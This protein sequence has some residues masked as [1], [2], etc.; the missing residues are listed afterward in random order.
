MD[1]VIGGKYRHFKGHVYKVLMIANDAESPNDDIKKLVI[2]QNIDNGEVWAREKGDFL[3]DVPKDK[4]PSIEQ[5][6]RFR[7]LDND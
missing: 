6:E 5:K 4:Y 7:L 2:Y 3:S 1:V